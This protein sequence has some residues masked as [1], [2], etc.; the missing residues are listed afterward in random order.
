MRKYSR[1]K[2]KPRSRPVYNI[3]INSQSS[4][5]SEKKIEYLLAELNRLKLLYFIARPDSPEGL[6][7]YVKSIIYK[8]PTGIIVCG[9]D[10][11][12]NIA[13]RNLIRR[14]TVLGILPMGRFNNIYRSLYGEPDIK[15]A[16]ERILS[17][18]ETKID[19]GMA[20]G[21]FFL[22][23]IGLGLIPELFESLSKKR[24]PMF[25]IG[26]SR[27]AAQAAASVKIKPLSIKVD[28]FEFN[29]SPQTVSVNLLPYSAGLP[30][31]PAS[32]NDDGK[33]EIIFD[34]GQ[35]KAIMSSYIRLIYKRK[36]IYS[37]EIRMFR[38]RSISIAPVDGNSLYIDGEIINIPVPELK[39]EIM[40]KKIRVYRDSRE[41]S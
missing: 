17:G 34:I 26:W 9:G 4:D 22:G 14:K 6:S 5:Y 8:K 39:V 32:L 36:Y 31:V 33:G 10:G 24:S 19:C 16:V 21:R 3:V 13:A 7:R 25:S 28:A 29:L 40:E 37:D 20:S 41:L 1:Q 27:L 30:L 18:I 15:A 12:V 2:S 38:G 11:T 35:T 23:S